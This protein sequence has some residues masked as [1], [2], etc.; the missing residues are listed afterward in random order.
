[1]EYVNMVRTRAKNSNVMKLDGSG[2]AA[3]YQVGLYTTPWSDVTAARNAVRFERKI[4]LGMEGHRF[5][6]LVR[7]GIASEELNAYL[8]YDGAILLNA[9]GGATYTDRHEILPIPQAQID[10][11]GTDKLIQNPGF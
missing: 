11:V 1:R 9:L 7:W 6:D 3:N 8:A 4:E 5:Y 10:L 2:P